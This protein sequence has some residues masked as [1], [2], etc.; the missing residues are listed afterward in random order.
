M[1]SVSLVCTVHEEMGLASVSELRA[2]L[3]RFQPQVIFLEVPPAAFCDYY[4]NCS[5]QNLESKAVTQY[6]EGHRVDLVPVDLPTPS[7][8][9]FLRF[10]NLRQRIRNDSSEYR[11]LMKWDS[12]FIVG[13]GFAYLNSEH[14]SELWSNVHQ[15]MASAIMRM[16][17]PSLVEAFDLWNETLYRREKEM[18]K[19]I[20][21]YCSQN[22]FGRGMFLVG[23][24]HRRGIIN[25]ARQQ[26]PVDS[27]RI[28]W[29]FFDA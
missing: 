24:A 15:E 18:V 1:N 6:R 11:R 4:E 21:I 12:D 17:D 22:V 28:R 20:Q 13:S 23:A 26:T 29:E 19:R 8:E 14:C 27:T 5:R 25:M 2:I 16:D 9:F 10:E 7:E 3:E